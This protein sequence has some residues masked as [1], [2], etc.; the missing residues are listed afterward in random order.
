MMI[1]PKKGRLLAK[2]LFYYEDSSALPN[3]MKKYFLYDIWIR[4]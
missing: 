1:S 4:V 2:S 3:K